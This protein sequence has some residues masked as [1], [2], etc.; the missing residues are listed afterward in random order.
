L[1]PMYLVVFRLWVDYNSASSKPFSQKMPRLLKPLSLAAV[2]TIKPG[3]IKRDGGG[4]LLGPKCRRG[5][6]S[7][8]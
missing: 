2:R 4:V 1:N 7:P 5:K 8:N 6:V 3:Q